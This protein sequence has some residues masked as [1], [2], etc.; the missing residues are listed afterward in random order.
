MIFLIGRTFSQSSRQILH[1]VRSIARKGFR[2]PGRSGKGSMRRG[3]H[4]SGQGRCQPGSAENIKKHQ[5]L[6]VLGDKIIIKNYIFIKFFN[7]LLEDK[8]TLV[9]W[10]QYCH[11]QPEFL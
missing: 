3:A 7:D 10:E 8:V 2:L 9:K 11:D 4:R 6:Y 1:G 5:I